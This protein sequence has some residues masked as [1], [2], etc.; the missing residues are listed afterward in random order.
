MTSDN[1]VNGGS[2]TSSPV[3]AYSFCS[4]SPQAHPPALSDS[5]S[6][7]DEDLDSDASP[8]DLQ[9]YFLRQS[10][11][12]KVEAQALRDASDEMRLKAAGERPDEENA[13]IRVAELE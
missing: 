11:E 4:V 13:E 12:I 8:E 9:Q 10:R 5:L 3:Q 2:N 7:P 6:E 1:E